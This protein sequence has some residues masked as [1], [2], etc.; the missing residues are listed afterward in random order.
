MMEHLLVP[1]SDTEEAVLE[2]FKQ[3]EKLKHENQ[4][5]REENQRLKSDKDMYN[6]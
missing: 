3:V 1:L 4:Q 2:L 5:L 6:E